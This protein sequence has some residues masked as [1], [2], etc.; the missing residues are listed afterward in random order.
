[1]A[2]EFES[3]ERVK[4][5]LLELSLLMLL[6]ANDIA[7][8]LN[9]IPIFI[10]YTIL[11]TIISNKSYTKNHFTCQS[12][13]KVN[14]IKFLIYYRVGPGF[15]SKCL[16]TGSGRTDLVNLRAWLFFILEL[17]Y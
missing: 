16:I 13:K 5:L 2:D 4:M 8:N 10:Q 11:A 15:V 6:L 1:M 17:K 7:N 9:S 12:Q 14:Y 3:C